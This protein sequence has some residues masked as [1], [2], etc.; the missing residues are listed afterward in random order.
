[1][2]AHYYLG[3]ALGKAWRHE[4]AVAAFTKATAANPANPYAWLG[5]SGSALALG[6]DPQAAA[7]FQRAMQLE[8]NPG[9][10]RGYAQTALGLGRNETAAA[11]VRNY[12][13]GVGLAEQSGNTQPSS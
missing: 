3:T 5:L 10:H 2:A 4:E 11:S 1:M 12:L 6:R 9:F 13:D 7:T 8:M